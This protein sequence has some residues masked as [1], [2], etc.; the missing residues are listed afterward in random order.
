M[1]KL[2]L[3]ICAF[4]ACNGFSQEKFETLYS[5][6]IEVKGS[7]YIVAET[8]EVG[9]TGLHGSKLQFINTS[10]GKIND[11]KLPSNVTIDSMESILIPELELTKVL[12]IASSDQLKKKGL[13]SNVAFVLSADG[14]KMDEIDMQDLLVSKYVVNAKTGRVTFFLN[15]TNG[16]KK[17]DIDNQIV[18]YDL[19][20]LKKV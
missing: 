18:I 16:N 14:S 3:V 5:K 4:V 12:I 8:N 20:T 13:I 15:R 7:E 10:T 19:K 6:T 9:S 17:S 2:F 11:V 1:K